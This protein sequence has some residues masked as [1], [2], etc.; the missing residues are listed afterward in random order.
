MGCLHDERLVRIVDDAQIDEEVHPRKL[1]WHVE[2]ASAPAEDAPCGHQ[3]HELPVREP[4]GMPADVPP[5]RL[6]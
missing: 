1:L 5:L 6:V 4:D 3:L 2:L